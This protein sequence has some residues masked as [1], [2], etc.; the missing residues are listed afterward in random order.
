MAAVQAVHAS[1]EVARE[2]FRLWLTLR[3]GQIDPNGLPK[4]AAQAQE[5]GVWVVNQL[6]AD[7]AT[8][9][10]QR[11]LGVG[12]VYRSQQFQSTPFPQVQ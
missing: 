3:L 1:L 10:I 8:N 7:E 6:S 5:R 4:N 2:R 9:V 11:A 12:Y